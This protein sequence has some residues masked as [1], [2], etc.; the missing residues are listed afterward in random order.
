MR[1]TS[2]MYYLNDHNR[3]GNKL[4]HN[5]ELSYVTKCLIN[6]DKVKKDIK[7]RKEKK[8]SRKAKNTCN[9]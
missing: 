5:K 1:C 8:K 4:N 6:M 2:T 7:K 3:F 9:T